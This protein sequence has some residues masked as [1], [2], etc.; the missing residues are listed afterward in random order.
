MQ[1][2]P[3]N[4]A[5]FT[6]KSYWTCWW[7]RTN[8]NFGQTNATAATKTVTF[9]FDL[10]ARAKV[11]SAKVHSVWKGTLCGFDKKTVAGKEPDAN[12]FVELDNV[13]PSARSIDVEFYFVA[14]RHDN[15]VEEDVFK[16]RVEA[17]HES[18]ALISEVYLLIE[19]EEDK[20]GYI[21][22]AENGE[23]VPYVFYRAEGG[24]LVPYYL[25]G[26]PRDYELVTQNMLTASGDQFYTSDGK[27][28]QVVGG[29]A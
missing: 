7:D 8:F 27:T 25:F 13:D 29:E 3:V 14:L 1:L 17:N 26:A 19:Y 9:S 21:Y 6:L 5:G 23:F 16:E 24:V 28:F 18:P 20:G 22:H 11:T 15:C 4:A 10:P 12:G 2:P